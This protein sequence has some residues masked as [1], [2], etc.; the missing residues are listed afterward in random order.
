MPE[1]ATFADSPQTYQA[2][3]RSLFSGSP[4][5][6]ETDLSR[7]LSPTFHFTAN[8]AEKYDFAGFVEHIRRLREMKLSVDLTTVEF[9]RDGNLLAERHVSTTVLQDGKKMSAETFMFAE[10]A[11]DGRIAWIKEAVQSRDE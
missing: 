2:T 11:G 9:L 8:A 5:D 6:T 3:L 1:R 4:Q 10:I 7:I